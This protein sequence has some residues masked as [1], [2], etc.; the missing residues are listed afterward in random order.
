MWFKKSSVQLA[1]VAVLVLGSDKSLSNQIVAALF[2]SLGLLGQMLEEE[3]KTVK[4]E[5]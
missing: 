5:D 4:E 1:A 2:F 3:R